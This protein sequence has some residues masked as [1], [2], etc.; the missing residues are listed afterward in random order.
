M[1]PIC[2]IAEVI[3]EMKAAGLRVKRAGR[4]R[5]AEVAI[6]VIQR[7]M[8]DR[9]P[10]PIERHHAGGTRRGQLIQMLGSRRGNQH[11]RL[12]RSEGDTSSVSWGNPTGPRVPTLEV[13]RAAEGD[14]CDGGLIGRIEQEIDL[15]ISQ[16][17]MQHMK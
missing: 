11:P 7:R 8:N 1:V 12:A 16:I 17:A 13:F 9:L 3:A 2:Q 15:A 4:R 14:F 6:T 5:Q 10:I